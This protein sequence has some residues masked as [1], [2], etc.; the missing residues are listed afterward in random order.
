MN[1]RYSRNVSTLNVL[2]YDGS[3]ID[4]FSC[5]CILL[6]FYKNRYGQLVKHPHYFVERSWLFGVF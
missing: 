3:M 6:A 4:S 5:L 2:A 1:I